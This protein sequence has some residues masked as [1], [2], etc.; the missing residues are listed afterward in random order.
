MPVQ[1]DL[2]DRGSRSSEKQYDDQSFF[3]LAALTSFSC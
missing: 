3:V 1:Q 2:L